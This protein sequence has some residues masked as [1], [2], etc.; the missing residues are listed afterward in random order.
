[1]GVLGPDRL[2]LAFDLDERWK[3]RGGVSS[4]FPAVQPGR[5]L[6]EV[7]ADGGELPCQIWIDGMKNEPPPT[8]QVR[9]FVQ[10]CETN[11]LGH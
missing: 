6:V 7:V 3:D 9:L 2:N 10:G 5:D 4:G 1:M 11:E 8:R